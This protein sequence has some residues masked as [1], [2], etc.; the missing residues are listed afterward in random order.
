MNNV[1]Y[2]NGSVGGLDLDSSD[3][4]LNMKSAQT[5]ATSNPSGTGETDLASVGLTLSVTVPKPCKALVTVSIACSSTTDFE[6]YARIYLNGVS[7]ASLTPVAAPGFGGNRATQRTI[8][9]VV[10]L[11]AGVNTITGRIFASSGTSL[12]VASGGAF[13]SAVVLGKVTA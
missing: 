8:Q 2:P 12:N 9:K 11:P 3:L 4:S 5:F 6:F 10:D 1:M 13:I 7:Q